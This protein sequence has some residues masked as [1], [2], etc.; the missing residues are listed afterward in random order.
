MVDSLNLV[1]SVVWWT[2]TGTKE[3]NFLTFERADEFS[4]R[5]EEQGLLIARGVMRFL[6]HEKYKRF[7]RKCVDYEPPK[8]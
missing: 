3:S 6:S 2:G 1:Y 4:R 8:K 5:M 7:S